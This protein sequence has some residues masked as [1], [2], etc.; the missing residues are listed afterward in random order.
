[1][2]LRLLLRCRDRNNA[3][4]TGDSIHTCPALAAGTT[5]L[6]VGFPAAD[7]MLRYTPII[8]C[9]TTST[10]NSWGT[11]SRQLLADWSATCRDHSRCQPAAQSTAKVVCR[12][13]T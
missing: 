7:K 8:V 6:T 3:A 12:Y 13:S 9:H 5:L 2:R 11:A 4:A 1:M 10:G